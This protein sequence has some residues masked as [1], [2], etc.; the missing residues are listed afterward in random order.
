MRATLPFFFL[1]PIAAHGSSVLG[2]PNGHIV[3][4]GGTL[5]VDRLVASACEGG[6]ENH[7][8]QTTLDANDTVA[9][10]LSEDDYCQLQVDL[11]WTPSSPLVT[12]DVEGF[13]VFEVHTSGDKFAI[14]LDTSS[15]DATLVIL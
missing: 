11:R 15:K 2:N 9:I 13:S 1:L 8:T 10:S 12:V 3:A 7:W 6:G 14:E 5:Y 4:L